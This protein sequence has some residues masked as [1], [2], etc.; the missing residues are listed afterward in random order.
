MAA[1]NKWWKDKQ[2]EVD[3]ERSEQKRPNQEQ[4]ERSLDLAK[5]KLAWLQRHKFKRLPSAVENHPAVSQLVVELDESEERLRAK[6]QEI[7][8]AMGELVESL[9]HGLQG[10]A[11]LESLSE[12]KGPLLEV[13]PEWSQRL[14]WSDS[15]EV[16]Q[17][18]T[19]DA[20][21]IRWLKTKRLKAESGQISTDTYAQC[22]YCIECFKRWIGS[23]IS[24]EEITSPR[25]EDYYNHLQR[26]MA[27]HRNTQ[28]KEG[29]APKTV[30][31]QWNIFRQYVYWLAE[32]E[33]IPLPQKLVN[34]KSLQI[35]VPKC[36]PQS[37]PLDTVKTLLTDS[38]VPER[39][40]LYL[41]LMLN[42]GAYQ[43]DIA[44]LQQAEVDWKRRRITRKRTKTKDLDGVPEVTYKLWDTTYELLSKYRAKDD[45]LVL[46][47][48]NGRPL[49]HKRLNEDG[50][51]KKVDAITSAYKRV[52]E[53]LSISY[54]LGKLRKTSAN[55][56]FN[57][58]E[59]KPLHTLFLGHSPK[60]VAQIHYVHPEDG[61]LDDA[62]DWLAT[63]YG[64]K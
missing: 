57:H 1:A 18:R 63:Q 53:K 40:R 59:H 62:I 36:K 2:A 26:Q 12:A 49:L 16:P 51:Y 41:L 48:E 8:Q 34:P 56:L 37:I 6:Y 52:Q 29:R 38:Q 11:P 42:I 28:G 61:T 4:W 20:T 19:V 3:L 58:K 13:D 35:K 54:S 44:S 7:E 24:V 15:T 25:V 33:Y 30:K 32:S 17:D 31:H 27:L 23:T 46:L 55:L 60:S 21:I 14:S 39:T 9:E 45:A 50:A 47:N 64:V 43:V 10:K 5:R 22:V